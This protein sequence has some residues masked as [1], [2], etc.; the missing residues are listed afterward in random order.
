MSNWEHTIVG[1]EWSDLKLWQRE[2]AFKAVVAE[3]TEG[4]D[5]PPYVIC[6]E[7]PDDL[8]APMKITSPSPTWWAM[9]LHGDILPPV[10]VYHELAKDEAQPD[11]KQHTRGHLLHDT[12]PIEALTEEEAMEYLVQKDIPP[13]VWRDYKGNRTILKIVPKHLIPTDR[14]HRDAWRIEQTQEAA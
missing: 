11:F 1:I 5:Q 8:D 14:T 4:L 9:A 7:D 6:W 3:H 10:W 12:S 13:R 2:Q